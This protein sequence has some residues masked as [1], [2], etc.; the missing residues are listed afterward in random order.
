MVGHIV[1]QFLYGGDQP[2]TVAEC[3]SLPLVDAASSFS[4]NRFV[5]SRGKLRHVDKHRDTCR[6]HH[7]PN[8][9]E[10]TPEAASKREA[11]EHSAIFS[12]L[13][14]TTEDQAHNMVNLKPTSEGKDQ[15]CCRAELAKSAPW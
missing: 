4:P 5:F 15:N 1:R 8:R 11:R 13:V 7:E 10:E 9:F 6:R 2:G 14:T 3:F 12:D